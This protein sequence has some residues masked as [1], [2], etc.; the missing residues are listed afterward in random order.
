LPMS[1]A[2]SFG[3]KED[4]L[5]RGYAELEHPFLAL[6]FTF[7]TYT[8]G[9]LNKVT[10]NYAQGAVRGTNMAFHS[11]IAMFFGYNIVKFRTPEFAWNEMDIEDKMLRAFD[12]SGLAAFHSD[13][14][15]RSL[16]MGMAF[17]IENPTPFEPKFKEDPDAMGGVV[18]IFGAPA[19]YSY[20]FIKVLQDFARGKYGEGTEQA[21]KQ[22]PFIFNLFLKPHTN[23]LKKALGN[24][25]EEYE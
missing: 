21:V 6:P 24:F 17:D 8:V 16:E 15:Y 13:M 19:D 1:L 14:F 23:K 20:G 18:S 22:I 12:F 25:A 2:K 11:A 5:V 3:L 4:K 9:A 10:T 7:Y